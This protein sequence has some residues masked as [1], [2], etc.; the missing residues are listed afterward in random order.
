MLVEQ[1]PT[2]NVEQPLHLD[3]LLSGS[4]ACL[5]CVALP[6]QSG[7]QLAGTQKALV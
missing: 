1:A 2:A 4:S 5:H 7:A 6:E 3:N